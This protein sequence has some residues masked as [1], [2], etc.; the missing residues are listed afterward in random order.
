MKN[1]KAIL[2]ITLFAALFIA[3]SDNK[4]Q[5]DNPEP[6]VNPKNLSIKT[7]IET[8]A[9]KS[10][11]AEKDEIGI[12]IKSADDIASGW[13]NKVAG[14]CKATYAN[15]SWTIVPSV[16]LSE[17]AAS[18]FAY[19][20]FSAQATDPAA[21]P[22]NT[23]SQIDYLYSGTSNTASA[24]NTTVT[25]A[26]RHAQ[27]NLRF[28]IAKLD[29]AGAATLQAIKIANR[30]GKKA[31]SAEGTLNI[32]TGNITGKADANA[33]FVLSEINKAASAQGWSDDMPAAMVIPFK[34]QPAGDI[35]FI[36]TIDGIP[37]T[38]DCPTISDGVQPGK[39]YTFTFELTAS[40]LV[41]NTED[42]TIETWGDNSNTVTGKTSVSLTIVTTGANQVVTMPD[43]GTS[44]GKIIFGD[45]QEADYTPNLQHTYATPGTYQ[46]GVRVKS[47]VTVV[48]FTG[49]PE[50]S[51]IDLSQIGK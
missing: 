1:I 11:F 40:G 6:P 28:N 13:Y 9:L 36:V 5:P 42:I 7:S 50:M 19:Y 29:Y 15:G 17:S 37:Y 21:V 14:V 16:E 31:F 48:K 33:S 18:V 41:L 38:I 12:F 44:T 22:I 51:T 26:M 3:C 46:V 24:S 8:R 30:S 25:L 32:A 43:M 35:Q 27:A 10:T 49:I 20:P 2:S 34:S 47:K 45:G 23:A 39:Q 4:T